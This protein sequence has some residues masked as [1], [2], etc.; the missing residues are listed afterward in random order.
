MRLKEIRLHDDNARHM[1]LGKGGSFIGLHLYHK[2]YALF[3]ITLDENS[4]KR[5]IFANLNI[6]C[7]LYTPSHTNS[8]LA[9]TN[10]VIAGDKRVCVTFPCQNAMQIHFPISSHVIS[11]HIMFRE[12]SMFA[13]LS[14]ESRASRRMLASSSAHPSSG[15]P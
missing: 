14:G 8:A 2:E 6:L 1:E 5:H 7:R 11:Y 13:S 15:G 12:G 10:I 9:I 4:T 3:L